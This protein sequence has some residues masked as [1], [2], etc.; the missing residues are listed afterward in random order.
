MQVK[1]IPRRPGK[2]PLW[3]MVRI[4]TW[5]FMGSPPV[6]M[7]SFLIAAV[8]IEITSKL[9]RHVQMSYICFACPS[10]VRVSFVCC[11]GVINKYVKVAPDVS[12]QILND[13]VCFSLSLLF[14][15]L[16][17]ASLS[18]CV[19][20]A[21]RLSFIHTASSHHVPQICFP[22]SLLFLSIS[23]C[24]CVAVRISFVHTAS[25]HHIPQILKRPFIS[26]VYRLPQFRR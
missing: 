8:K 4:F 23:H 13:L 6:L 15:S 5:V 26:A 20:V 10:H 3:D 11:E 19:C 9:R 2:A 7:R 24:V 21:V 1:S 25:S 18:H 14:L 16:I 12:V 17:I 22:L